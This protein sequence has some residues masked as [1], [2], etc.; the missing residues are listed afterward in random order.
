MKI[1]IGCDHAGFKLKEELVAALKAMGH[2]VVDVGTDSEKTCDYPDYARE[3]A[4]RVAGGEVRFGV[5]ICGTGLGM[6]MAANR[7]AGVRGA[8]CPGEYHA[9]LARRH[10]D[11]NVLCLGGRTT[12]LDLAVAILQ[13]FL[14]T[15]FEGGRHAKRVAK[16]EKDS[17]A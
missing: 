14:H 4:R 16:L 10:N 9:A 3:V 11:A 7:V 5:L 8:L 2:V 15:D 1:A 12:G 6:S 17:H 13:R